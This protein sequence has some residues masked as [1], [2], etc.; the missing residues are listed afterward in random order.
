MAAFGMQLIFQSVLPSLAAKSDVLVAFL[1]WKLVSKE[2]LCL[3]SS[4]EFPKADQIGTGTEL[5]PPDWNTDHDVYQLCYTRKG[6][7]YLVKGVTVDG[8]LLLTIASEDEQVASSSLEIDHHIGEDYRNFQRAFAD[9]DA[10]EALVEK[11]LIG[12]FEDKPKKPAVSTAS[13]D[14]RKDQDP[15]R[16]P[17]ALPRRYRGDDGPEVNPF[18]VGRGDLDPL[19]RG[20]GGG[21]LMD[22]RHMPFGGRPQPGVP[23]NLPPGAVPPGARFDPF[24][25]PPPEF[26]PARPPGYPA[27]P[28]SGGFPGDPDPDHLPM[29]GSH[30][31]FM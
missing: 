2:F 9:R 30:D 12:P 26:I 3:G 25:P 27:Q 16:V 10:L 21:M 5:L 15:L 23:S 7:A 28:R 18:A 20:L 31:M 19:G 22:P 1:H 17:R 14:N 24:G 8:Q 4:A 6:K 13:S 29:P 11:E